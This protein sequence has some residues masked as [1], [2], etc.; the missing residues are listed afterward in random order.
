MFIDN[1]NQLFRFVQVAALVT[2][3]VIV[4]INLALGILPHVNN[5][6]H[7]GG[8]LTGFL[9]GFILLPR[10]QL[11]WI[12]R[13]NLPVQTRPRSKYKVSQYVLGLLSL[14]LVI[15]GYVLDALLY[16]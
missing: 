5:F 16:R 2:L 10:P 3:V 12:E 14:I 15:S 4:V 13:H 1:D 7:I 8:F 11:G 9:L 6:A